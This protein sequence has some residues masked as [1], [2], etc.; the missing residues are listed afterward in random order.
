MPTAHQK[1]FEVQ[2]VAQGHFDMQPGFKP[3]TFR[4]PDDLI[5][6]LSYSR[7]RIRMVFR[8]RVSKQHD[9]VSGTV[10]CLI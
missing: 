5:H 9:S 2:Y 4:L 3:A 10:K 6:L 7:P 8:V 1:Q